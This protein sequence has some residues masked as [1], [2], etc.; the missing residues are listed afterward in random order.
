MKR[1]IATLTAGLAVATL[2]GCG[3]F[4]KT[5]EER[6]DALNGKTTAEISDAVGGITCDML[7]E[8]FSGDKVIDFF[9]ENRY[10]VP[11]STDSMGGMMAD[12]IVDQCPEHATQTMVDLY[13]AGYY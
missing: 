2:T 5:Y 11:V 1:T 7:D 4:E 8:G 9:A 12:G 13:D 6:L 10:K 3:M